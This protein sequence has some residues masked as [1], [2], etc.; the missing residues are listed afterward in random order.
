MTA[1][2]VRLERDRRDIVLEIGLFVIAPPTRSNDE[3][4]SRRERT[5]W[6]KSAADDVF[7][8]KRIFDAVQRATLYASNIVEPRGLIVWQVFQNVQHWR[9]ISWGS[10]NPRRIPLFNREN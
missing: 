8:G 4:P 9:D 3:S 10:S 7:I 6:H 1:S 5:F 2:K